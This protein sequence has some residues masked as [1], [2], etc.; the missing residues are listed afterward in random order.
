MADGVEQIN[1]ALSLER[2]PRHLTDSF[3]LRA[4]LAGGACTQWAP[5]LV[6]AKMVMCFRLLV[7]LHSTLRACLAPLLA[8]CCLVYVGASEVGRPSASA[9]LL[10]KLHD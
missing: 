6:C 10:A 9:G 1:L 3:V 8:G 5:P 7:L 4:C 2:R